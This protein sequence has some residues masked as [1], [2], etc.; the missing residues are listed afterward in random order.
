MKLSRNKIQKIRKQQHQ[1]VRKWKKPYKSSGRRTTFRQSRRQN[2]IGIYSPK[3][4]NVM[5]RTLKKYISSS[6]LDEAK[7]LYKRMRRQ[8]RK[9]KNMKGGKMT[10]EQITTIAANAAVVAALAVLNKSRENDPSNMKPPEASVDAS[11]SSSTSTASTASTASIASPA[12]ATPT[13]ASPAA[14]TSE[15]TISEPKKSPTT[16]AAPFSLGPEIKGDISIG[17]ETFECKTEK[18]IYHLVQFLIEKGL[19]YYIKIELKSGDKPLN[20]NDTNIFDLRRILYGKYTQN[21]K[22]IPEEKRQLYLEEKNTVGV[23]NGSLLGDDQSGF[24]I[25]TGEKGQILK[26]STDSTIK[27]RLL[28][29]DPNAAP[30]PALT[31]STRLYKLQGQFPDVKPASIDSMSRLTKLDKNNKIDTTEF[32]L[33]VAPMTEYELNKDAQ[34]IAAGNNN[35]PEAKIVID[36]SNTYVVNLAVGCK[37]TSIQ[38]LKKSLEKAR[39]SLENDK[40]SSKKSALDIFKMLNALLQNPEFAKSDGY[41]DFKDS[42]FGFSYKISDSERL[43]GFTQMQTFFGDDKDNIPKHVIKEFFKLMNLLGHGPGGANG[44]CLRFDGTSQ[45]IYE[46][47]RIQTFE[48]DGK[49]VTKK[50]ETLDSPSKLTGFMKQLSKL[51]EV[52]SGANEKKEEKEKEGASTPAAPAPAPAPAPEGKNDTTGTVSEGAEQRS[53]QVPSAPLEDLEEPNVKNPNLPPLTKDQIKEIDAVDSKGTAYKGYLIR[54]F[55]FDDGLPPINLVHFMGWGKVNDEYIPEPE[56][57]A[58][59][60]ERGKYNKQPAP[61]TGQETGR[62]DTLDMVMV[63]YEKDDM[64]KLEEEARTAAQKYKDENKDVSKVST[65]VAAMAGAAAATAAAQIIAS[66]KMN[67]LQR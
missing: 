33:Q 7:E 61:I 28:Q 34:N 3:V 14:D 37:V 58:R 63:L 30:I 45:S 18:E 60:F 12:A 64:A 2:L 67:T 49:I 9:Q 62:D 41:D 21:I 48:E 5:N 59:I 50:T 10:P 53:N 51:G 11:P 65:E 25:Y 42:V 52:S 47:S 26:E 55:K 39:I 38:T 16:S 6:K 27:I 29:D 32:R 8:R 4:N 35:D 40:D 56:A 15:S 31:D 23:A 17:T 20:K 54:Q 22:K 13:A 44:D 36:E 19:P 43:Y 46:L 57:S 24:F 66:N 1:S